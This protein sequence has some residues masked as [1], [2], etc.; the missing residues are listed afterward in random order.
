MLAGGIIEPSSSEWASP[1]LIVNKKDGSLRLCV[2]YRKLNSVSQSDMY[3]MPRIYELIDGLSQAKFISMFDLTRG[4]WQVPVSERDRFKTAFNTPF[5]S[6]QFNM[7]PFGL[8]GTPAT[9]QRIM[10]YLVD[11]CGLFAAA[12]LDDLVVFSGSW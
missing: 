11:G 2:D 8:Q 5:G 10:D 1:I 12:Y 7:M 3:P 4:L 9:F 6:Y